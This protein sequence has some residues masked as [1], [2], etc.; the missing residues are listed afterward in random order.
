MRW[1]NEGRYAGELRFAPR[2]CHGRR[3]TPPLRERFPEPA[4]RLPI[5]ITPPTRTLHR[6]MGDAQSAC[7]HM[8]GM[9]ISARAD[10][11]R[12]EHGSFLA[13]PH[14]SPGRGV[15]VARAP[16]PCGYGHGET[17][18][19]CALRRKPPLIRGRG[20]AGRVGETPDPARLSESPG[21]RTS[22]RFP[23][24]PLVRPSPA[25]R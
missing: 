14:P 6:V 22:G 15:G 17:P 5:T 12:D 3:T 13:R 10:S 1:E 25:V 20:P 2:P 21:Q 18:P 4:R 23:R 7:A 9:S 11:E 24:R 8:A 16:P 19:L